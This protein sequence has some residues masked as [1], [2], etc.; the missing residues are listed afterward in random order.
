MPRISRLAFGALMLAFVGSLA[1]CGKPP[2][3]FTL[4][5]VTGQLP[6]LQFEL[7]D[8]SGK[9]RTAADYRGKVVMLFFGYTHCPDVCPTTLLH[10][11]HVL[12]E[13]GPNAQHVA[14]LFVTVDPEHDTLKKLAGY[15]AA[16]DPRIVG[17]RGVGKPLEALEKRYHVYVHKVVKS[18]GNYQIDHTASIY[19]FDQRGEARLL[20]GGTDSLTDIAKD[21]TKL[22]NGA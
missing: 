19:I 9:Q 20:A 13:L 15:T 5:D 7:E 1:G 18:N 3:H 4:A 21:V 6:P 17:L 10:L 8:A 22:V 2:A 16:F 12:K 14:M 11:A